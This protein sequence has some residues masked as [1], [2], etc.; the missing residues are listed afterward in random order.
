MKDIEVY[1]IGKKDMPDYHYHKKQV[2]CYHR[3]ISI[4]IPVK[5]EG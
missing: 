5:V 3:T 2:P 1:I 4:H